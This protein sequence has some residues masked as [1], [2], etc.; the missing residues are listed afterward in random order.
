MP[1]A[2]LQDLLLSSEAHR[3][4]DSLSF[5]YRLS[6]EQKH[7]L[8]PPFLQRQILIA[9]GS[10]WPREYSNDWRQTFVP[11]LFQKEACPPLDNDA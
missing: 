4:D 6:L 2:P 5:W 3:A 11:N 9:Q 1:G 8:E 10:G 7:R